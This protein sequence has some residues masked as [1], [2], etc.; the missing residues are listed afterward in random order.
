M[1]PTLVQ[2]VL[3]VHPTIRSVLLCG[4]GE[5]LLYPD[6]EEVMA[7]CREHG[8]EVQMVSNGSLMARHA[9]G[10]LDW[11][12]KEVTISLNAAT[13]ETHFAVA[14]CDTWDAVM[15]GLKELR[16]VGLPFR[17]SMVVCKESILEVPDFIRLAAEVGAS[18]VHLHN[19]LPHGQPDFLDEVITCE[20]AAELARLE[21]FKQLPGAE[22]VRTW[23]VPIGGPCPRLCE[24]PFVSIGVDGLGNLT[25]CRRVLPPHE[26]FGSLHANNWIGEDFQRYRGVMLGDHDLPVEC[27]FCFGAWSQ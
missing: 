22:L 11:G 3:H 15:Y 9:Q 23:P 17:L 8:S 19:L 7:I 14:D 16:G 25:P 1:S 5:P 26:R 2:R 13:A 4:F 21:E 10:L 20:D 24:S 27:R 6:M 18:G 12:M